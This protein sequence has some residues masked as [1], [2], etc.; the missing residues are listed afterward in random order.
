MNNTASQQTGLHHSQ[1]TLTY[2]LTLA[3]LCVFLAGAGV[4]IDHL[5]NERFT[6]EQR[7]EVRDELGVLRARLEG[8]LI[9]NI[10]TVQG[11]VAAISAN[12]NIDQDYF[13]R[14]AKYLFNEHTQLKNIG[15]APDLVIRFIYPMIGNEAALGLDYRANPVQYDAAKRA[16]DSGLLTIAG[17]VHLAQGGLGLIGRIPV[18]FE[19]KQGTKSFWGLVSAVIDLEKFYTASGLFQPDLNLHIAI[20]GHDGLGELGDVF[21]GEASLFQEEVIRTEI[22]LPNGRWIIA[23]APKLGWQNQAQNAGVLRS[24]LFLIAL[25]ILIPFIFGVRS[26]QTRMDKETRLNSLF[27]LSPVGIALNDF[28]TGDFIEANA[29]LLS[30]TGYSQEEFFSLSYWD[31]TPMEYQQQEEIQLAAMNQTGR[32]GPYEKEYIHK[33]GHRLPVLLNGVVI[34]DSRGKKLIWSIVEDVSVRNQTAKA[35]ANQKEQLELVIDNTAVGFW[36]WHI[37]FDHL[38]LN[39]RW[40]EMMGYTLSELNPITGATRIQNVH[41]DDLL[42]CAKQLHAH[43]HGEVDRYLMEMRIKHRD[44]RWLWALDTGK[45]VEWDSNGQPVRMVG[46]RIDTTEQKTSQE[47]IKISQHQLQNF[48]DLSPNFMCIANTSGYFE[49]I[50]KTFMDKLGYSEEELLHDPIL[51]FVH[52][53]D[54]LATQQEIEKL[55]QGALTIAFTNRYRCKDHSYLTLLWQTTPDPT[56]GKLYATAVDITQHEKNERKL[57][58]QQEML[59]SMS[60]QAHIGAWEVDVNQQQI[61]WSTMTKK[62]HEVDDDYNLSLQRIFEFYEPGFARN[63]LEK[64]VG[65]CLKSGTPWNLELPLITA[66]NNRIWVCTTGRAEFVG[67]QCVRLFGSFQDITK[68]KQAEQTLYQTHLELESQMSLLQSIADAQASFIS[69]SDIS[70]AFEKLLNNILA[71]TQSE[72]GFISEVMYNEDNA[73]ELEAH[74]ISNTPWHQTPTA[75]SDASSH[76]ESIASLAQADLNVL[77]HT[78]LITMEPSI[79]NQSEIDEKMGGQAAVQTAIHAFLGLPI[80]RNNKSIAMVGIANRQGGYNQTIVD[81]LQPLMSTIGQ[82]VE[83]IRAQRDRNEVEQAL[84]S[85]KDDALSAVKAK[86]EFLAM[87]SH[88]IRTPLNGIMGMLNLLERSNL[89][90]KQ[91]RK[92]SIAKNSTHTLLSI[93]NDIL[94]FSKVDAGKLDLEVVDFDLRSCID[95]LTETL[96]LRAQEKGLELIL[97]Q[98]GVEQDMA[99]GDPGRIRQILTNLIGNAIKFTN[100]GEILIRCQITKEQDLL[101]LHG[102]VCDSGIGIQQ[103]QLDRLFEP[104]TQEDASTTRQYGG[105]G[106]GLAIC[107]KLCELMGGNIGAR[108]APGKGST[109]FF[110]LQLQPSAH[111]K[112]V[113]PKENI[114]GLRLLIV[115]DNTTHRAVLRRQLEHWGAVVKDAGDAE[116]AQK[117]CQYA[118][119]DE[120]NR[121][122]PFDLALLDGQMPNINGEELGKLL[123][124][125]YTAMPLVMMSLFGQRGDTVS[126][127]R[128]G[129]SSYIP[130]PVTTGD[131]FAT[132]AVLNQPLLT[133]SANMAAV[134]FPQNENS[135]QM[136][137]PEHTR[138]LLV[139]D[140]AVNQEVAKMVLTDFGLTAD[141]AG[142]GLEA[143]AALQNAELDPYSLVLMDCQMPEMDGYE[144][145]TAIRQG[146]AGNHCKT[147]A[148]IAMTA[149]A[150]IGDKEKC[151]QAGMNDYLTKP[152]DE[153]ELLG[154]L[155]SWLLTPPPPISQEEKSLPTAD[156]SDVDNPIWDA[157]AALKAVRGKPERL[158]ILLKTFCNRMPETLAKFDQSLK[159]SDLNQVAYYA[160]SIKG[161]SGQLYGKVLQSIASELEQAAKH[162]DAASLESLVP[163]FK[164]AVTELVAVFNDYLK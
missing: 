160:H 140:N 32:Y 118:L 71:L 125:Q 5:N 20:K 66:K 82:I 12:P 152:I 139:E 113:M 137:W 138:I 53:K 145:S 8:N 18:Y 50:N 57:A 41:P 55:S 126:L 144:A 105:T 111:A 143:I 27:Q 83:N 3:T 40:A 130:K 98:T 117:L 34:S 33:D 96:A 1:P 79:L 109:F 150:M 94:D 99:R 58:Q 80:L 153:V 25:T 112:T 30:A 158:Q 93:I 78:T 146:L 122:S 90:T 95:E 10:Q 135:P 42:N 132:L 164:S 104:F 36:D 155:K 39:E 142:N 29:A 13:E 43:W 148:I 123:H 120:P 131:L 84:I 26:V 110:T 161:S 54:H 103:G 134:V 46:T 28:T 19:D 162:Y 147:I 14:L 163:Q 72:Y 37:P 141:V 2:W 24:T 136:E 127:A 108:S 60:E 62:I 31:L 154:K 65:K 159:Q 97:D 151:L 21:F 76:S 51:S 129:F 11:L 149:N 101:L 133:S 86:S 17:P 38:Q 69:Q 128:I 75:T 59:E 89:D 16:R 35:I 114:Q 121:L 92:A 7:N 81:W 91:R 87:M 63:S 77:A 67:G 44:G 9:T 157:A 22:S 68:R 15:G 23:A 74:A 116:Q 47:H 156:H 88:E 102:E 56:T 61:Y 48:F 124:S 4:Y 119:L 107:K 100:S 115:D 64:A 70:A 52:I 45:V 106:L 6:Q 73:P 85:A 49:K